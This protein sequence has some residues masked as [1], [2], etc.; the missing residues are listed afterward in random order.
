MGD[1]TIVQLAM[2][3][4]CV[5]DVSITTII[6]SKK[7]TKQVQIRSLAKHGKTMLMMYEATGEHKYLKQARLCYEQA[8][9]IEVDFVRPLG[10]LYNKVA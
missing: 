8:K 4:Q 1:N 5:D 10:A 2:H 9:S 3:L 7:L 6:G